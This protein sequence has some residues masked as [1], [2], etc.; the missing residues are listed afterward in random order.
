MGVARNSTSSGSEVVPRKDGKIDERKRKRMESNRESA[1]R[2][3]MRKQ[4]ELDDMLGHVSQLQGANKQLLV[5][6]DSVQQK[7]SVVEADNTMLRAQIAELTERLQSLNSVLKVVEEVSGIV[8]DI[9]E[10]PDMV[11]RQWQL[12][13]PVQPIA[14][15]SAEPFWC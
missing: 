14:A 3:R 1:R 8:L 12:P 4:K 7:Y 10:V 13:C 6:I 2:S 15:S 5:R 9:P 11:M